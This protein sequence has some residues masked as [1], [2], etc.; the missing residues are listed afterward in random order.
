MVKLI[1]QPSI[2][3][4]TLVIIITHIYLINLYTCVF[5]S[6]FSQKCYQNHLYKL[7]YI[8]NTI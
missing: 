8:N 6:K 7:N 3:K 1:F 4:K 2:N 5:S